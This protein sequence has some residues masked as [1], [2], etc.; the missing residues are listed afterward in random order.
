[1]ST[2]AERLA[3]ANREID[4]LSA[5]TTRLEAAL[6]IESFAAEAEALEGL[7]AAFWTRL[8]RAFTQYSVAPLPNQPRTLA[9]MVDAA[10]WPDRAPPYVERSGPGQGGPASVS[11]LLPV[12]VRS[13]YPRYGFELVP[14]EHFQDFDALRRSV[15][16]RIRQWGELLASDQRDELIEWLRTRVA[17]EHSDTVKLAWYLELANDDRTG[18][19]EPADESR[20]RAVRDALE[21]PGVRLAAPSGGL[22]R[23]S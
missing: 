9:E 21:S 7:A 19:H 17:P 18:T 2:L 6:R 16:R 11:E 23:E 1:V 3:A 12:F 22:E 14:R 10:P 20:F 5:K 15:R 8:D 4:R 13:V